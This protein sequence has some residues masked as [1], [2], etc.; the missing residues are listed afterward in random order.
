MLSRYKL[1]GTTLAE[2]LVVMAVSGIVLLV[3]TEGFALFR[4]YTSALTGRIAE[5]SRFYDGYYR[6]EE[7]ASSADSITGENGTVMIWRGGVGSE[8]MLRDSML[9]VSY[10]SV[11]DTLI[12][13]VRELSMEDSLVVT[14]A[15]L[16]L[17]Y[18]KYNNRPTRART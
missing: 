7:L 3:A 18:A 4:G 6:L 10:G 17:A 8:L 5:N 12:R 1:R 2:V 9:I 15:G 11:S 13:G 14:F 16:R